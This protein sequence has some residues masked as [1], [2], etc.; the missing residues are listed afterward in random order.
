M[1][2]EVLPGERI[3]DSIATESAAV[4]HFFI[5]SQLVEYFLVRQHL[6]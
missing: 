2:F 6:L 5:L 3:G 1:N 4:E